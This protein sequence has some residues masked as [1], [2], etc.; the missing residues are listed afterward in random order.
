MALIAARLISELFQL[1]TLT[2]ILD[3]FFYWGWVI[4]IVVFQ[5][6]IRRGLMRMGRGMLRS[7]RQ[8]EELYL[9]EE[10]VRAARCPVLTVK[11]DGAPYL[12]RALKLKLRDGTPVLVDLGIAA[13]Q[14]DR[15]PKL[16]AHRF[17]YDGEEMDAEGLRARLTA[18]DGGL[19]GLALVQPGGGWY[20]VGLVPD[21][22]GAR[23]DLSRSD[24]SWVSIERGD[25]LRP[26]PGTSFW[27][28]LA[29][30]ASEGG[31]TWTVTAWP[32]GSAPRRITT[33]TRP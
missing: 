33:R 19:V 20:L 1:M 27:L 23:V 18:A 30:S 32:T 29:V 17:G 14:L 26:P 4:I 11:P 12:P 31:R 9:V 5:D 28:E 25:L 3:A 6:D 16:A 22:D 15:L 13:V 24:G 2:W 7:R 8:R 21:R 10:V